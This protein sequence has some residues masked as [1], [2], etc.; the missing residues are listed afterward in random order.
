[1]RE[2]ELGLDVDYSFVELGRERAKVV[3][4]IS[5]DG[6]YYELEVTSVYR[7]G[8][9]EL[10]II[11]YWRRA[12]DKK[13]IMLRYVV[14]AIPIFDIYTYIFKVPESHRVALCGWSARV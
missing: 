5:D 12:V 7:R 8:D 14:L 13:T 2:V 11:S 4:E 9:M 3:C 1:M 10:K 6:E